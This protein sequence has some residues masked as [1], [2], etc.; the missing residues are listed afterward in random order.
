MMPR[1]LLSLTAA[2][3]ILLAGSSE[4]AQWQQSLA[5]TVRRFVGRQLRQEAVACYQRNRRLPTAWV[6]SP[7]PIRK[8]ARAEDTH[9][10]EALNLLSFGVV[11]CT[12]YRAQIQTTQGERI[13]DV[14]AISSLSS[15]G[16]ALGVVGGLSTADSVPGH[17]WTP[18]STSAGD[19]FYVLMPDSPATASS[20][21]VATAS[22]RLRDGASD[23]RNVTGLSPG[24]FYSLVGACNA[25]DDIDLNVA[26]NGLEIDV[27]AAADATPIVGFVADGSGRFTFTITMY[28]CSRADCDWTVRL[29]R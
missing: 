24:A 23:T 26:R 8:L 9:W 3:V 22:G 6:L 20:S 14:V 28:S 21:T 4:A 29:R 27:D 19:T 12:S 17:T 18:M 2:G 13:I 25:C 7:Y 5:T 10:Q 16:Y 1:A 11:N 15:D